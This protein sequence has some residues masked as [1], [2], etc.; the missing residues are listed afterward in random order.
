[1]PQF[2]C[3]ACHAKG[4]APSQVGAF[5]CPR[6]GRT[7]SLT[8]T[9]VTTP[10][11]AEAQQARKRL[12]VSPTPAAPESSSS[13]SWVFIIGLLCGA[14]LLIFMA[15]DGFK[16]PE[17]NREGGHS[18]H[19]VVVNDENWQKEVLDSD[20]PVLV[21]FYADWCGPCKALAPT[22][23]RLADR[24]HGKVKIAKLNVDH[25]EKTSARYKVNSIPRLMLF[26]NGKSQTLEMRTEAELATVLDHVT[27]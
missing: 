4:E 7:V 16:S 14:A 13:G 17:R 23:D 8:A 11:I 2:E 3:P 26:K 6:C 22:I 9:G 21:D 18:D 20:V 19:I 15:W 1:V 24:F 27:Q 12:P 10:E 25:A 5:A